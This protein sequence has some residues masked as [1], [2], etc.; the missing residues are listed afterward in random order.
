[1]FENKGGEKKKVSGS[2]AGKRKMFLTLLLLFG[3]IP[4]PEPLSTSP[5][6]K[7]ETLKGQIHDRINDKGTVF[8][9]YN[10]L[11]IQNIQSR[12][13]N[14]VNRTHST[15]LKSAM[16]HKKVVKKKKSTVVLKSLVLTHCRI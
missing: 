7:S 5:I 9:L 2:K 11:T 14:K 1:M 6:R 8:S 12:D 3:G 15:N 16:L 13:N 10:N 4:N